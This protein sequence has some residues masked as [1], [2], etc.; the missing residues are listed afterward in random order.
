MRPCSALSIVAVGVVASQRV[1]IY[2]A[3]PPPPPVSSILLISAGTYAEVENHSY[4]S[5]Y[6]YDAG[7]VH[8]RYAGQG[9][10]GWRNFSICLPMVVTREYSLPLNNR[11]CRTLPLYNPPNRSEPRWKRGRFKAK[12]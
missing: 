11:I 7:S 1:T 9:N 8:N 4:H 3:P 6:G 10:D 12:T 5:Y 2:Q